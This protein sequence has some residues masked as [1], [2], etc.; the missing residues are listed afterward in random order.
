MFHVSWKHVRG[1]LGWELLLL[2]LRKGLREGSGRRGWCAKGCWHV[3]LGVA[4]GSGDSEGTEALEDGFGRM[5]PRSGSG[6]GFFF[7]GGDGGR[8]QG[9]GW[10]VEGPRGKGRGESWDGF[11]RP[12]GPQETWGHKRAGLLGVAGVLARGSRAGVQGEVQGRHRGGSRRSVGFKGCLALREFEGA[13]NKSCAKLLPFVIFHAL[14]YRK[15][16]RDQRG[17]G[18]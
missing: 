16:W 1:D 18:Q 13:G 15:N 12:S 11:H 7:P 9:R 6:F 10:R 4:Q 2:S 17:S 14:P 3:V 8:D 5:S